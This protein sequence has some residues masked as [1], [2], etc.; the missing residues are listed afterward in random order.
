MYSNLD[1][2]RASIVRKGSTVRMADGREV[3][4]DK[5]RTGFFVGKGQQ[6]TRCNEVAVVSN[7]PNTR[8]ARPVLASG[9]QTHWAWQ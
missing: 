1:I 6:W 8:L 4:V 3:L 2:T 7:P 9:H 5:V